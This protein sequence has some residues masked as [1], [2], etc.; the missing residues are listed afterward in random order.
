MRAQVGIGIYVCT[1]ACVS[2]YACIHTCLSVWSE[3]VYVY[4]R[5]YICMSMFMS[6]CVCVS[7]RVCVSICMGVCLHVLLY[8][9]P[10]QSCKIHAA[11]RQVF[12][13]CVPGTQAPRTQ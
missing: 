13:G 5:V 4:L 6:M 3:C 2:V 1:H 9:C 11:R 8:V 12:H 7:I 10:Q